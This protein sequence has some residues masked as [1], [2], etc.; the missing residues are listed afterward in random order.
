MVER[1]QQVGAEAINPSDGLVDADLVGEAH[2]AG[3]AVY[4]YTVDDRVEIDRLLDLGVDGVFS[5]RPDVLREAVDS[6]G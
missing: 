5:N 2:A 1:A 6:R 3:L 4:T